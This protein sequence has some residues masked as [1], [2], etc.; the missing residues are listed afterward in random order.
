MATRKDKDGPAAVTYETLY[1]RLF[2]SPIFQ[3][4]RAF[5]DDS[6]GTPM[7]AHPAGKVVVFG[8][9]K[10]GNVWLKS[11]I[12]DYTG[13]PPVEPMYDVDKPGVG[14]THLPFDKKRIG[15]R[16]D[17]LHGA[18]IVRDPRDVV[19]SFYKYSQTDRFRSARPEFHCADEVSFYF[20]WFLGRAA[21]A[22]RLLTHSDRYARLGVPV[23]RYEALRKDTVGELRR[24]VL[25]WGLTV[26]EAALQ[27]AVDANQ[28]EKLRTEGKNLEKRI[29]PE[30]FRRG[31]VGGYRE[32]LPEIVVKDIE[33]RFARV[34]RRWGY[35][36]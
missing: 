15:D 29:A 30:H 3:H 9:P 4:P 36:S 18:L 6:Y 16:P 24:L 14:L 33:R 12:A 22:Y 5:W 21:P 17:F 2:K 34:L 27:R 26:D 20:D 25:R 23:V 8:F 10:S 31:A 13:L 35:V 1:P 11:L 32:E 28:L 7:A 19:A